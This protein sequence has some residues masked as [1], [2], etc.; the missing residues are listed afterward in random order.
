M[1]AQPQKTKA[2]DLFDDS[3]DESDNP[4]ELSS[5]DEKDPF[6]FQ[7][8][9]YADKALPE[10]SESYYKCATDSIISQASAST[11]APTT[12]ISE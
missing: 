10:E 2:Y 5:E 4:I 9:N 3:S 8:E 11:M 1:S 7:M 6:S 12:G